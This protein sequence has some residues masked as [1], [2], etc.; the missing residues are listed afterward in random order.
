MYYDSQVIDASSQLI[1]AR[2]NGPGY[3]TPNCT[4]SWIVL[5]VM[6]IEKRNEEIKKLKALLFTLL[7]F[8]RKTRAVFVE[9]T[10]NTFGQADNFILE[11]PVQN[12]Q[13]LTSNQFY[14][15]PYDHYHHQTNCDNYTL[16]NSYL[17]SLYQTHQ[18][19]VPPDPFNRSDKLFQQNGSQS[20][21]VLNPVQAK[22]SKQSKTAS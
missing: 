7:L 5:F 13:V 20:K 3:P 15:Q 10:P 17:N 8:F 12:S 19:F 1:S 4:V 2:N 22:V 16:N 14:S 9:S 6:S 18:T 11:Y 21:S